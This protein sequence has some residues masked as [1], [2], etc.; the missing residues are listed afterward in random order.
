VPDSPKPPRR[1]ITLA[2]SLLAAAEG[3]VLVASG[4][5]KRAALER[6]A[7]GDPA[8]PASALLSLTVVADVPSG[9]Q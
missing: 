5:G 3:A 8:L 2:L 6:L 9:S 7:A 1:R 4:T